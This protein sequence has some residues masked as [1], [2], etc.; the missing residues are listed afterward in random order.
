MNEFDK[1]VEEKL[2]AAGEIEI[3]QRQRILMEVIAHWQDDDEI[4]RSKYYGQIPLGTALEI[5]RRIIL[6]LM[7]T[8]LPRQVSQ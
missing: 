6:R 7:D 1:A 2:A 5:Q 8:V 3:G 4:Y